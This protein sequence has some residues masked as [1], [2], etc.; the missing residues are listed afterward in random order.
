[1]FGAP[2]IK[3]FGYVNEAVTKN[4]SK[5]M[6]RQLKGE[7]IEGTA[8]LS[9]LRRAGPGLDRCVFAPRML[10]AYEHNNKIYILNHNVGNCG[11]KPSIVYI[12]S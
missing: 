1:M 6:L 11:I 4:P 3:I 10:I 2:P 7:G 8:S 9:P 12:K 5:S